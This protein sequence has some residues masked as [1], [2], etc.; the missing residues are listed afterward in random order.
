MADNY[1]APNP[2]PEPPTH[3]SNLIS[4]VASCVARKGQGLARD[5]AQGREDREAVDEDAETISLYFAH[6]KYSRGYTR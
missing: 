5:P 1:A 4:N 6:N 2:L 3:E